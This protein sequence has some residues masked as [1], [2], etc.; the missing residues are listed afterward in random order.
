MPSQDAR[1]DVH[2]GSEL[3]YTEQATPGAYLSLF[4]IVTGSR[5]GKRH[6][7]G[8]QRGSTGSDRALRRCS[9]HA[10]SFILRFFPVNIPQTHQRSCM[11][12]EHGS[13]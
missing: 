8:P 7:G 4:P 1:K 12:T 13:V 6:G 9:S 2:L 11:N 3:H 10:Q 5:H